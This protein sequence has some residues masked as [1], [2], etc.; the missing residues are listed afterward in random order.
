[1]IIRASTGSRVVGLGGWPE[2]D[3]VHNVPGHCADDHL[4]R[5]DTLRLCGTVVILELTGKDLV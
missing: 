2:F 5:E 4:S 3:L 1:M